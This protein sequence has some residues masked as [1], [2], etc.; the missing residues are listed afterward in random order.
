MF[1][2]L[3]LGAVFSCL[4]ELIRHVHSKIILWS[5]PIGSKKSDSLPSFCSIFTPSVQ[6]DSVS[7]DVDD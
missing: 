7:A 2:V 6:T 5:G 3:P 4:E 1:S